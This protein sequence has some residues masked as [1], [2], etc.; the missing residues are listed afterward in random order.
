LLTALVG[1]GQSLGS[2]LIAT[3]IDSPDLISTVQVIGVSLMQGE[4]VAMPLAGDD[5]P[6]AWAQHGSR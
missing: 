1:V 5:V 6:T 2:T 4:T 3:G